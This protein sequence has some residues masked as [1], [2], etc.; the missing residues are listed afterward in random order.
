VDDWQAHAARTL[1]EAGFRTGGARAR[2]LGVLGAESCCLSAQEIFARLRA[3]G[4]PVG[5]ASVYRALELLVELRLVQRVELGEGLAR[6]EARRPDGD[7]HHHVVCDGCGRVDAFSDESLE[8]ALAE[9]ADGVGF[10][11]DAHDV[12]LRGACGDCRG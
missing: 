5:I 8:A 9:V 7:H 6:Y 12:V 4:S 11:V 2:V 3:H 10:A 1:R